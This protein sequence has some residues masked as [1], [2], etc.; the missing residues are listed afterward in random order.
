M[1][2][3]ARSDNVGR[4]WA[5]DPREQKRYSE[6]TGNRKLLQVQYAFLELPKVP[7]EKPSGGAALD[8]GIARA[9]TGQSANDVFGFE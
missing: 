6:T 7:K 1:D 5:A 3:Q 8:K 2:V 9:I 4:G